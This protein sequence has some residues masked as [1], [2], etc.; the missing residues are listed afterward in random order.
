M[1]QKDKAAKDSEEQEE[2]NQMAVYTIARPSMEL[3]YPALIE[4]MCRLRG[5]IISI[6]LHYQNVINR[7][8]H[9]PAFSLVKKPPL[10]QRLSLTLTRFLE[11]KVLT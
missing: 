4:E 11:V 5:S 7:G 9:W 3:L 1:S 6:R 2:Q 8:H 10:K